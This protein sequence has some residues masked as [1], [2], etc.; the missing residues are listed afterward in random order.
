MRLFLLFWLFFVLCKSNL[1][2]EET[3]NKTESDNSRLVQSIKT[4]IGKPFDK[5]ITI[6]NSNLNVIDFIDQSIEID[7][8]NHRCSFKV[9]NLSIY[10]FYRFH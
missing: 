7:T 1:Q 2:I 5:S 6:E 4:D 8:H 3:E 9:L 10:R